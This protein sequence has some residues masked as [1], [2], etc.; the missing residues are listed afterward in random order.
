MKQI[1][2]TALSVLLVAAFAMSQNPQGPPKPAPELKRLAFFQGTWKVEGE[3]KPGPFGPGGKMS[4]TDRAAW[5]LGRAFLV[6][7]ST[8][9]GAGMNGTGVSYLGYDT[10]KKQ[11]TY[12]AFN[13][14]GQAEHAT[15]TVNDKTWTWTSESTMNGQKVS[16]RG[17]ITEAS[18]TSYTMNFEYSTDEGKTWA[19][20]MQATATK[21]AASARATRKPAAVP[22]SQ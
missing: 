7:H 16:S 2:S 10:Q 8:M 9:S 18:P 3:M 14:F 17:T 6:T 1:L 5:D 22:S 20:A 13:S 4:G 19:P 12:D 15:G 21:Q 11:Y